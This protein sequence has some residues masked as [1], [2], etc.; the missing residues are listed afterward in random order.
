MRA[1]CEKMDV[2]NSFKLVAVYSLEEERAKCTW[3]AADAVD[4]RLSV[5]SCDHWLLVAWQKAS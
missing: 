3:L 2:I 5:R 1:L 4:D